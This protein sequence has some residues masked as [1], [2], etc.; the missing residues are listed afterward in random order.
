MA[1]VYPHITMRSLIVDD[2]Y[3][4][5]RVLQEIVRPYGDFEAVASGEEALMAFTLSQDEGRPFE[6]VLLDIEMS[7]MDGHETLR[8]LREVEAKRGIIG[9]RGA[10]VVMTTVRKD[11]D[12]VFAAFRDQ[13]EAY[14]IKPV[15]REALEAHLVHLRLIAPPQA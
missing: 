12:S 2:E 14:L 1:M 10:K 6:L 13:C 7:G 11:P 15:T 8:R 4:S 5:R 9:R 3:I